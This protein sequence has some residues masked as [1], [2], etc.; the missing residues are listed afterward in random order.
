[1]ESIEFNFYGKQYSLNEEKCKAFFDDENLPLEG[2]EFDDVLELLSYGKYDFDIE[3]FSSACESCNFGIAEKLKA[4]P[5]LEY[6][7]YAF[8]NGGKYVL[9]SLS[10]EYEE[11][12]YEKL[13]SMGKVEH[14]YLVSLVVCKECGDYSIEIEL[15]E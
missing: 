3:Y 5:F 10:K 9:S 7:F 13:M 2:F 12:S 6:H 8:S 11:M 15:V 1:M 14:M 4:F